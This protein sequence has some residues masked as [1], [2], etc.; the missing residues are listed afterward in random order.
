MTIASSGTTPC[1]RRSAS[2]RMVASPSARMMPISS[3]S[4]ELAHPDRARGHPRCRACGDL[5][6]SC[7]GTSLESRRPCGIRLRERGAS[8]IDGADRDGSRQRA[9]AHLVAR[10]HDR[11]ARAADAARASD[12]ARPRLTSGGHFAAGSSTGSSEGSGTPANTSWW[13]SSSPK[14]SKRP[15]VRKARPT[16]LSIGT[17]PLPGWSWLYRESLDG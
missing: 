8:I 10:D 17:N 12:G 1:A 9:S 7:S 4:T 16:T 14:R 2:A 5:G 11:R 13:K 3:I 6:A 15:R